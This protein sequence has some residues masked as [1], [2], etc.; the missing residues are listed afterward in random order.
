MYTVQCRQMVFIKANSHCPARHDK[1]LLS[2]LCPFRWYELDSQQLKT[3]ADR[4]R[5]LDVV[6]HAASCK[7]KF[8]SELRCYICILISNY[9]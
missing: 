7:L 6:S 8:K 2:V 4:T 9:I 3:V 5:S 1:T